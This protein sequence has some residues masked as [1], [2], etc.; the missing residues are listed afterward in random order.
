MSLRSM[1]ALCALLLAGTVGCQDDSGSDKDAGQD[2]Q[3]FVDTS[4]WPDTGPDPDVAPD[5][6]NDTTNAA[7]DLSDGAQQDVAN[8]TPQDTTTAQDT[9][10]S[11]TA[12]SDLAADSVADAADLVADAADTVA[13]AADLVDTQDNDLTDAQ[14]LDIPDPDLADADADGLDVTELSAELDQ[15]ELDV[16]P[17]PTP[18]AGSYTYT[19]LPIGGLDNST[20]VEFH[21]DGTYFIVL[22]QHTSV[23]LYD[24]ATKTVQTFNPTVA[25]GT[26]YW[27]HLKF[28]P[29]G[30]FATLLGRVVPSGTGP[31]V[32][33]IFRFDDAAYRTATGSVFT[34]VTGVPTV[35]A[36][37]SMAYPWDGGLPVVLA[38]T[39]TGPAYAAFLYEYDPA[40]GTLTQLVAEPTSAGCQGVTFV[41]NEYGDPGILAVCGINGYDA[42]Y[43]TEI[44][45]V[46][47]VRSGAALGNTNL[48]NTSRIESYLGGTYALAVSNSGRALYR[49]QAGSWN[50]YSAAPRFSNKGIYNLRFKTDGSRTLIVGRAGLMP[51]TG[52]VLEYRHD[53]YSCPAPFSNCELSDVGVP[54][55]DQ[56]PYLGT[57]NT[58]FYDA[59]WRPGCEGGVIVGGDSSRGLAVSFQLV[60]GDSCGW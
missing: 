20:E 40:L 30:D 37:T 3:F 8:D 49:F 5:L 29:S 25:G 15:A 55:F 9:L 28:D 24:V 4:P 57:S 18:S 51:T 44:G 47:E 50:G 42:F 41:N 6:P 39:D 46:P 53:L 14:D 17:P 34:Q 45:G 12:Q 19:R 43:F 38:W 60:G 27:E 32:G 56:A 2:F 35:W 22:E 36:F 26:L 11:D 52:T 16:G 54:N 21:P 7:S 1:L 10:S 23:L 13:D 33:V 31:D 58:Y 48:G 59:D